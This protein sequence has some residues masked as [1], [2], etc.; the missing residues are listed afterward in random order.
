MVAQPIYAARTVLEPRLRLRPLDNKPDVRALAAELLPTEL[1]YAPKVHQ[2]VPIA[3]WLRGP[4]RPFLTETLDPDRLIALGVFNPTTV[5]RMIHA[6]DTHH[7][8]NAWGLWTIL[9]LTLWQQQLLDES[10]CDA[11][12]PTLAS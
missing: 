2:A 8:D 7:A 11:E 10:R 4:L 3:H 9:S 12:A 5:T 1:A 6:H